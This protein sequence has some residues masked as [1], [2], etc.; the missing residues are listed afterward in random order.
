V[1]NRHLAAALLILLGC[2]LAP[3]FAAS[4]INNAGTT[5]STAPYEGLVASRTR[6]FTQINS[7]G[8]F[9]TQS[10][11]AH[12]ATETLT[13]IRV[14]FAGFYNP[15]NVTGS[16]DTGL[17]ATITITASVEYNGTLTQLKFS[18]SAT[19]TIA[20]AGVLFSDYATV[21]IP[22]GATFWIRNFRT[23]RGGILFN[24]WQNKFLG[25]AT[26]VA[27]SGLTD[28]TMS[29]TIVDAGVGWSVPPLA[30]LGMTT[31]PS[32]IIIGDSIARGLADTED[33]SNTATGRN[34]K[35]G[36]IARSLG[37]TPF[38]NLAVDGDSACTWGTNAL[39]RTRLI[40]KGSHLISELGLSDVINH[41]KT[42]AQTKSALQS[43]YALARTG[44]KIYQATWTPHASDP[45]TP[46]AA[47]TTLG[48]QTALDNTERTTFNTAARSTLPSTLGTI[49][50][51]GVLE[52][53][54]N[55]GKWIVKPTPP[56]TGDS[57][58][59]NLAGYLLVQ[60]ADIFP[61]LTYP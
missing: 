55:S 53:S 56:Y 49:D 32:V 3:Q 30:I 19:G 43:V 22:S 52:S 13:S 6:Q 14:A 37:S 51:A 42:A 16:I 21:S 1:L 46:V 12:I 15:G 38:L 10:R 11:S 24:P 36:V 2:F 25:E 54:L 44:Q 59:P 29:G 35:I 47:W 45:G 9:Q 48:Q 5:A 8:N 41:G 27:A 34:G 39:A 20:N 7:P 60:N 57:V 61:A 26:E 33:S 4:G 18:S 50:V 28:K 17:G 31:N 40:Q 23:S 58:H